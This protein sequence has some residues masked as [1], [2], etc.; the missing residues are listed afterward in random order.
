MTTEISAEK[1][2]VD[3]NSKLG[4][5]FSGVAATEPDNR[6]YQFPADNQS[7]H[8]YTPASGNELTGRAM[9]LNRMAAYAT[10]LIASLTNNAGVVLINIAGSQRFE[11]RCHGLNTPIAGCDVMPLDQARQCPSIGNGIT[12]TSAQSLT[13]T[14]TPAQAYPT[15][16]T[17]SAIG[18]VG[19]ALSAQKQSVVTNSTT[20]GQQIFSFT[21]PATFTLLSWS[22]SCVPLGIPFCTSMISLNDQK[23]FADFWQ[24]DA[25]VPTPINPHCYAGCGMGVIV[26][27]IGGLVFTEE[28]KIEAYFGAQTIGGLYSYTTIIGDLQAVAAGGGGMRMA[29]HGGLAA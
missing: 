20:A 11:F 23:L 5:I 29:G 18:L 28:D 2:T 1:Y 25:G 17:F 15:Y 26:L 24:Q 12:I 3:A 16:W 14:V 6:A 10:T 4:M 21:P 13:V 8:S 7:A 22:L 27:P 19:G 9:I